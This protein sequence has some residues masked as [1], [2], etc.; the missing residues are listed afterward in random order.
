LE[1]RDA[2]TLER[3]K[4]GIAARVAKIGRRDHLNVTW[5]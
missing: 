4:V 3:L 1:A 5:S 2:G